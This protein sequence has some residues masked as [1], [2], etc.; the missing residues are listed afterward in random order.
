VAPRLADFWPAAWTRAARC[1]VR[2]DPHARDASVVCA[3]FTATFALLQRGEGSVDVK[4][5][6]IHGRNRAMLHSSEHTDLSFSACARPH[7]AGASIM[8]NYDTLH[9]ERIGCTVANL[10]LSTYVPFADGIPG[11]IKPFLSY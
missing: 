9:E 11:W 7:P 1:P 3:S 6:R 4:C 5:S 10:F 8:M 2:V